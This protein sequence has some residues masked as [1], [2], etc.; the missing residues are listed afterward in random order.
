VTNP[1]AETKSIGLLAIALLSWFLHRHQD[2]YIVTGKLLPVYRDSAIW[3]T[4]SGRGNLRPSTGTLQK[5][6]PTLTQTATPHTTGPLAFIGS[7]S[8]PELGLHFCNQT[9]EE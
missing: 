3:T 5:H 4:L 1:A 6:M 9:K 7:V 8:R 2:N